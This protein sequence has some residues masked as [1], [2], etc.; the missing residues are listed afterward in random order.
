M[1]KVIFGMVVCFA[2][3]ALAGA[4]TQFT[5][6]GVLRDNLGA[7]QTTTVNVAVTMWDAQTGGNRLA[8]YAPTPVMATNGLFALA[9]DDPNLPNA[10][11]SAGALWMEVDVGGQPYPRQL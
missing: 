10:V 6:Q 3:A 8:G 4:P 2:T 11:R 9:I 1:R 7:L 5:V